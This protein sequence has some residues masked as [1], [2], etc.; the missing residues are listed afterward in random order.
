[1]D[2]I[3]A[4][5][6][7]NVDAAAH[8]LTA[9]AIHRNSTTTQSNPR[10]LEGTVSGIAEEVFD[11]VYARGPYGLPAQELLHDFCSGKGIA[12]DIVLS[13]I[14]ATIDESAVVQFIHESD[15]SYFVAEEFALVYQATDWKQNERMG[16]ALLYRHLVGKVLSILCCQPGVSLAVIQA[17]VRFLSLVQTQALLDE[18]ELDQLV[19]CMS[20]E[21]QVNVSLFGDALP[22][23]I[24]EEKSYFCNVNSMYRK[25]NAGI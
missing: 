8:L 6:S 20:I 13:A 25:E 9:P 23:G 5:F 19:S 10:G 18:M 1:M 4:K 14:Q 12:E 17:A 7:G 11:T 24:K 22:G 15:I 21:V 16:S 2:R 3:C